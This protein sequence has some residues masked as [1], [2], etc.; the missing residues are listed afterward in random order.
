MFE[1]YS[2]DSDKLKDTGIS[3]HKENLNKIFE[4]FPQV[5]SSLTIKTKGL[6]VGLTLCKRFVE[7]LGGTINVESGLGKGSTCSF[8]L[9]LNPQ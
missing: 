3:I 4:M 6:G 1:Q 9:P 7:L 5:D 2:K 8:F